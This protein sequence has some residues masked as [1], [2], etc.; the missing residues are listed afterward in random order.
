MPLF[1]ASELGQ[2]LVTLGVFFVLLGVWCLAGYSIGGHALVAK[3][4][5]RHGHVIVPFVLIALGLYIIYESGTLALVWPRASAD[6]DDSGVSRGSPIRSTR[7]RE[8]SSLA[9]YQL[10]PP[11]PWVR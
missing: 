1:A 7:A 8:T 11:G 3:A 6:V 10:T 9:W 4:L 2:L 5:D